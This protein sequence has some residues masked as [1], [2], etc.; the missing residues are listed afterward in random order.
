M[1]N[2]DFQKKKDSVVTLKTLC[3]NLQQKQCVQ[4]YSKSKKKKKNKQFFRLVDQVQKYR[5]ETKNKW[6]MC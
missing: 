5:S 1:I 4:I 2:N 3:A 6:P